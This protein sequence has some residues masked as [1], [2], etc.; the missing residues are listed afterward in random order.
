MDLAR[1]V[2]R[3]LNIWI[4][5][6]AVF[7][8]LCLLCAVLSLVWFARPSQPQTTPATA[9]FYVIPYHTPTPIPATAT[10]APTGAVSDGELP[11]S[12]PPGD[13]A[14]GAY[15]Q[16]AGTGGDGLRMRSQAG[17]EGEVKFLGLES[18]VFQIADGP[19]LVDGYTWWLLVAP[20]DPNIRGWAVSNYLQV[21]QNP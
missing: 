4:I 21:V 1:T 6:G 9:V 5:L 3:Y 15:V 19:E 11:P 7:I 10:P 2:G 8:A 18:E 14:E 12:P 20:Y 16:V 17:L 13:L